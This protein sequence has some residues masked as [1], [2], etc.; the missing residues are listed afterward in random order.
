MTWH[1]EQVQLD[2]TVYLD[3]TEEQYDALLAHANDVDDLGINEHYKPITDTARAVAIL[4]MFDP[5]WLMVMRGVGWTADP[6][7]NPST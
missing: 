2:V 1:E 3:L 5:E 6:S 4:L 7:P